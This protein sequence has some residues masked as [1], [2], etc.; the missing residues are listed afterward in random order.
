MTSSLTL[1]PREKGK[2]AHAVFLPHGSSPHLQNQQTRI[3]NTLSPCRTL[4]LPPWTSPVLVSWLGRSG[5]AHPGYLLSLR[6]ADW[7]LQLHLHTPSPAAPGFMFDRVTESRP[8]RAGWGSGG[9]P[10]VLP[11]R[12]LGLD[13]LASLSALF[14]KRRKGPLLL[15]ISTCQKKK[16]I[17]S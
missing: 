5:Q 15:I 14:N 17:W 3:T 11:P 7:G 2:R 6:T 1:P 10:W 12:W 9:L 16:L 4:S 13:S 8:M